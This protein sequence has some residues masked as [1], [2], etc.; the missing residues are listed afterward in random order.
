MQDFKNLRVWARA[1][2]LTLE[3][4][5]LTRTFPREE[6][7]GL[8]AQLR[9]SSA[10][11]G[12]N[13]AEGTARRGDAELRRFLHFSMGSASELQYQ[14]LLARDL[15]YLPADRYEGLAHRASEIKK[16]TSS[17]IRKLKAES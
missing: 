4:Y 17:L 2:E 14:L 15:G 13:M 7:F 16:M 3:I 5:A 8:A 11:I 1:H 6:R 12:M 10:S 9:R